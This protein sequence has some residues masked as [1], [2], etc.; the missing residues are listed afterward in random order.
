MLQ[1]VLLINHP[2]LPPCD[3]CNKWIYDSEWRRIEK[4]KG[5]GNYCKRPAG[6]ATPCFKCPKSLDKLTPN[7]DGDISPRN[8]KAWSFYQQIKAGRPM[9]DDEV[10]YSNCGLIRQVEDGIERQAAALPM[11]VMGAMLKPK[12]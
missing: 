4:P 1:V 12:G 10:A 6:S 3:E 5:S 9:P 11:M 8:W 2:E 7:P